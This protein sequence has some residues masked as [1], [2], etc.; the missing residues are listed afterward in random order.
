MHQ[1][2][3]NVGAGYLWLG[4]LLVISAC[5][6]VSPQSEPVLVVEA[7]LET[8]AELGTVRLRQTVGMDAPYSESSAAAVGGTV[9]L[10]SEDGMVSYVPLPGDPGTYTPEGR[11][12]L[13]EG[14]AFTIE[15]E[16]EGAVA[17]ASGRMPRAIDIARVETTI[18][19]RPIEV[20]L[21]DSLQL[22]SLQTGARSGFVYPI[23]VTLWWDA[24]VAP[25]D[26]D[27]LNWIRAQLKP[28]TAPVPGVIELLFRSEQIV[29]EDRVDRSAGAR[30]WTGVYLVP[31]DDE[32]D[33]LPDHLLKV[34]LLRSGDD[35]ARFASSRDAPERRE[36][37]SNVRGGIGIVA[38]ISVDSLTLQVP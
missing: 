4:I 23:E 36:P 2:L 6:A 25:S 20:V 3:R 8:D 30:H 7:F 10:L 27:S 38:G 21:L 31:V 13:S 11:P 9:R 16:W 26:E 24:D 33:P 5:D 22:D 18:P 1:F 37:V 14:R 35:Y 29:R 28:Y 34:A 19:E 17:V 15:A 12:V 32:A